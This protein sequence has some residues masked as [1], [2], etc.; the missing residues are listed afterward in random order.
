MKN[1]KDQHSSLEVLQAGILYRLCQMSWHCLCLMAVIVGP[2]LQ[3]RAD[4]S[5]QLEACK[6]VE[7]SYISDAGSRLSASTSLLHDLYTRSC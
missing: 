5:T 2:C 6:N 4:V 3:V 1:T 7:G